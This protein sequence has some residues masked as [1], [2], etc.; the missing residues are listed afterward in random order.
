M[1]IITNGSQPSRKG[2]D[3]YFTGTVRLDAPFQATGPA[4]VGGRR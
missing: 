4:R 3:E 2:P 1:K